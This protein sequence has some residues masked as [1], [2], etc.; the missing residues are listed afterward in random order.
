VVGVELN[1][2][3]GH[4]WCTYLDAAALNLTIPTGFH[5]GPS[6]HVGQMGNGPYLADDGGDGFLVTNAEDSEKFVA[7]PFSALELYLM[8]LVGPEEVPPLRFVTDPAVDVR[9]GER[10]AASDTRVVTI[11]DV[12][13]VYGER[14]P[15]AAVSARDFAAAFVVVSD[16]PLTPAEWTLSSTVARHAEGLSS[17]GVRAGGLFEVLAPPSFAAATDFRAT[18]TTTLP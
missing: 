11:G 17:G 14:V 7:N 3:I 10:I 16:R 2:E 5:W 6:T 12:V 4:R 1:H 8:G 18:L 13:A 15:A 9:F